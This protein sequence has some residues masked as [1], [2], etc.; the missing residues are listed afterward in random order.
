MFQ[1]KTKNTNKFNRHK[2][3]KMISNYLF[4]GIY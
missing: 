4:G 1:I 3:L 2:I